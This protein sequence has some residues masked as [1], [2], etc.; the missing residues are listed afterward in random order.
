MVHV[1]LE[2]FIYINDNHFTQ[3]DFEGIRKYSLHSLHEI[4]TK[5]CI[6]HSN[7]LRFFVIMQQK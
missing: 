6:S 5:Q 7:R 3:Y 1:S 4:W 2:R